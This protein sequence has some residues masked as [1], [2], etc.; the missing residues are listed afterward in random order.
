MGVVSNTSNP[1]GLRW[2]MYLKGHWYNFNILPPLWKGVYSKGKEFASNGSKF[3]PFRIHPFIRRDS[4]PCAG[5]Q[6][7][8]VI[9]CIP[10]ENDG[11]YINCIQSP[12]PLPLSGHFQQTT[13]WC[14]FS[15]FSQKT[16]FDISCKLSPKETICM[17]CQILFSGKK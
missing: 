8:S 6:T 7:G 12:K 5:K 1:L 16:G 4:S 9:R 15:Y 14:Y 10:C 2:Q 11:R 13:K 3:F 17:K